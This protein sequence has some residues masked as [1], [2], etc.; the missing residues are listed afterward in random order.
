MAASRKTYIRL[1]DRLRGDLLAARADERD[2]VARVVRSVADA[3]KEDN[4]AF[5]YDKFFEAVGLDKFGYVR[6][7]VHIGGG[8]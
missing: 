4:R 7:T 8:V 2:A 6:G 5:R 3:L 1:A